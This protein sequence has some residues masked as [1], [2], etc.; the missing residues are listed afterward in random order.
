MKRTLG[1]SALVRLRN[2]ETWA[3]LA[4]RSFVDW[5]DELIIVLN[6]CTDRTPEIVAE[7]AEK[8]SEKVRVYDY[9]HRIWEMGPRHQ[10]VSADDPR[11]SAALYNFT[12]SKATCTHAVKL[13]GDFVM[14]DWAGEEIRSAMAAGHDRVKFGG[15]DLVHDLK[16][17]GCEPY[18]W[19]SDNNGTF[20]ITP[21]IHYRQGP[22]TQHITNMPPPTY[23]IDR[24]AFVHLKW[25]KPFASAIKQW[26]ENWREIPHFQRIAERRHPVARY[27]G[28]YPASVR[29]LL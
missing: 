1:L 17:I 23:R 7:F 27:T 3:E 29:A 19:K 14:M 10:E 8:H 2:E 4:L 6:T 22:M 12:L 28:E 16:H 15:V 13:D 18:C 11:S 24:P 25:C 26:P 20:R 5:C 21:D 9:P